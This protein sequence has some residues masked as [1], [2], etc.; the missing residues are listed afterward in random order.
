MQSAI[1]GNKEKINIYAPNSI[2]KKL[3]IYTINHI[4]IQPVKL[5]SLHSLTFLPTQLS[6][7][8]PFNPT[9]SLHIHPFHSITTCTGWNNVPPK[10]MFTQNLR[11]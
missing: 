4:S 9:S 2:M 7:L 8:Y 5:P 6:T 3:R 1:L 10:F 11:I